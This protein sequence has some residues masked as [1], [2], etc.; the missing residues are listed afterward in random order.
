MSD[1]E[2]HEYEVP[3]W[4]DSAG[5]YTDNFPSESA[6][7]E[8]HAVSDLFPDGNGWHLHVYPDE[9]IV[10]HTFDAVGRCACGPSLNVFSP[11]TGAALTHATQIVH[12]RVAADK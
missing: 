9:D 8:G 7:G 12:N 4:R 6:Q 3:A 1:S 10:E 11:T 5:E 2:V